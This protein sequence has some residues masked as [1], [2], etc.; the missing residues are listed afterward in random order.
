M[1][2]RLA[3]VALPP[4]S[5]ADHVRNALQILVAHE[6]THPAVWAFS[7]ELRRVESLLFQAMFSLDAEVGR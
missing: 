5:A 1:R 2:P 4:E 3:L 7:P 6:A